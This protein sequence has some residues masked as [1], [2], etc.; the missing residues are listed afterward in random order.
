MFQTCPS[1]FNTRIFLFPF[2]N[3]GHQLLVS[4]PKLH[5]SS[6]IVEVDENQHDIYD[7]TC[8]NK[9]LMALFEDLGT[10]P[11]VMVR[12]NPDDYV[13][14]DGSTVSSCFKYSKQKGMPAVSC[15][16]EWENRLTTL[17]NVLEWHLDNVPEREVTVEHLYY[18]GFM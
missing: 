7:C 1:F 6:Y 13:T 9:R 17:K 12:F 16:K 14:K 18:D 11:L 10:R 3:A 15:K 2:A 8:E 4:S 5:V